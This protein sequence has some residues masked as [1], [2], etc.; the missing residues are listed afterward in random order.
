MYKIT[1]EKELKQLIKEKVLPAYEAAYA[2]EKTDFAELTMHIGVCF[3]VRNL[4][5]VDIY[6]IMSVVLAEKGYKQELIAEKWI[7]SK[8]KEISILPRIEWMKKYIKE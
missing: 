2:D 1:T 5:G 8:N 6:D 4:I 3:Y 7:H